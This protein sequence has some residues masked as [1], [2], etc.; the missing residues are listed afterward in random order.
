M[1]KNHL[2]FC[3][4]Y[5]GQA[6]LIEKKPCDAGVSPQELMGGLEVGWFKR[7]PCNLDNKS[8]VVCDK[9]EL[10]TKEEIEKEEKEWDEAIQRVTV[11]MPLISELKKEN[12]N[13]GAG[14]AECPCCGGV[15]HW[16]IASYNNHAHLK[17]E[18]ENCITLME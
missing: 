2:T 10:K 17:C 9:F 13:G 5:N 15:L 11:V 12:P 4:H 6:C 18:T 14:E 16:G 3:K 1:R 8:D 7:M